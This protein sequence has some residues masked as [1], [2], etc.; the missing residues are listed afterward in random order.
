MTAARKSRFSRA[1]KW[2]GWSLTALFLLVIFTVLK[3]PDSR[4]KAF[5]EGQLSSVLAPRGI[6]LTADEGYVSI[7]FGI[8]YVMKGVTLGFAPPTPPAHIEKITVAPSLLASLTGRLGGELWVYDSGS[9]VLHAS[10]ALKGS[11]IAVDLDAK[12]MDLGKLG[13]LPAAANVK[14]SVVIDGSGQI[15]GDIDVPG[16]LIG[17]LDFDLSGIAIEQQAILGFSIPAV[18][19]SEGKLAA[20]IDK[21]QIRIESVR[22]GKDNRAE[23]DIRG[24][25]TGTITLGKSWDASTL[26]LKVKLGLSEKIRKAFFLID[27]LLGESKTGEGTYAFG[28]SGSLMAP[29]QIPGGG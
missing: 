13:I 2:I 20:N 23:D 3:L 7:G 9:K 14:G 26:N 29:V 5:V 4:V 12:K 1:A 18:A 11:G 17:R 10:V 25:T 6:T 15:S 22:L 8:S 27:A 24:T 19:I 28:L 16:T 21:S